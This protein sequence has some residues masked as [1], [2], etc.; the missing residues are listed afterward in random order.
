MCGL[1]TQ[2]AG[3]SLSVQAAHEAVLREWGWQEDAHNDADLSAPECS[4]FGVT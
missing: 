2:N 3:G 1:L 4:E